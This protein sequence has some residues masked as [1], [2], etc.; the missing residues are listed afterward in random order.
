[1][2]NS[3]IPGV[4]GGYFGSNNTSQS[5]HN[6]TVTTG[7][8][9]STI[10]PNTLVPDKPDIGTLAK[11]LSNVEL[12]KAMELVIAEMDKRGLDRTCPKCDIVGNTFSEN[13]YICE[14]CRYG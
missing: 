4:P 13:D 12:R 5:N 11:D 14:H 7:S 10:M 3:P 8:G 2:A 1:M 9:T 6:W